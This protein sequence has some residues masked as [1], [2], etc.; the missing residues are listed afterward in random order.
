MKVVIYVSFDDESY[1]V[2]TIVYTLYGLICRVQVS[3]ILKRVLIIGR[4]HDKIVTIANLD[5]S[6]PTPVCPAE[7]GALVHA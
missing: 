4:I 3:N 6:K 7:E 2:V 5:P 1:Q